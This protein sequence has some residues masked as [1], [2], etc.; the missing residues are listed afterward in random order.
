MR[1]SFLETPLLLL[2]FL[3]AT[4]TGWAQ[5]G[6][7]EARDRGMRDPS[8]IAY[9]D[10]LT[11]VG[12]LLDRARLRLRDRKLPEA[13]RL[14]SEALLTMDEIHTPYVYA[15]DVLAEAYLLEGKPELA[16]T[17]L[18]GPTP[19]LP[20]ARTSDGQ[21]A[22]FSVRGRYTRAIALIRLGQLDAARTVL[23][24]GSEKF[25]SYAPDWG[26]PM[27]V[28][29]SARALEATA[30]LLR[31][32]REGLD[33]PE[34]VEGLREAVRLAPSSGT[35]H[36]LLSE[37]LESLRLLEEA[38]IEARRAQTLANEK[39]VKIL[40]GRMKS[41]RRAIALRDAKPGG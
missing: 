29:R 24:D 16:L 11:V 36:Y 38:L 26:L 3:A 32:D 15:H 19:L 33:S 18:G 10:A 41:I 20:P 27:D 2:A 4:T 37:Q 21:T 1:K 23:E 8:F 39:Q 12:K 13:E 30:E 31:A 9:R 17:E 28:D 35:A 5:V 25:R 6:G 14:A 7:P 40:N 34:R 22:L